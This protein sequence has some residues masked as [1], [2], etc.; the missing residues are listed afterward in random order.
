MQRDVGGE[1]RGVEAGLD[2]KDPIDGD[3]ADRQAVEAEA[4]AGDERAGAPG[5]GQH[6]EHRPAEKS[7]RRAHEE[8][9]RVE[10]EAQDIRLS[11]RAGGPRV[12]GLEPEGDTEESEGGE[13]HEGGRRPQGGR[14]DRAPSPAGHNMD[15]GEDQG[16]ERH[17][18]PHDP[19]EQPAAEQGIAHGSFS[20]SSGISATRAPCESC[21]ARI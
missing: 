6:R 17:R 15:H 5:Q 3:E 1:G 14:Q 9:R 16:A 4:E 10:V 8:Q 7:D 12:G 18:A 20:A 21:S 11:A 13:R 19:G 2:R